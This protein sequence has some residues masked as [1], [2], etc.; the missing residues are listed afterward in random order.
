MKLVF[1]P[2]YFKRI[3]L[4]SFFCS[5]MFFPILTITNLVKINNENTID[6][7]SFQFGEMIGSMVV[8]TH[9]WYGKLCVLLLLI[10]FAFYI[11]AKDKIEDDYLDVLRW[12]SVRLSILICIG[13]NFFGVLINHDLPAKT[14][15][16]VLFISYLITFFIKKNA[17]VQ[18]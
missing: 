8:D 17:S 13:L 14:Q 1:L 6:L 15:L 10:G 5:L 3:G 9:F 7:N 18:S 4:W 12:E 11:L 16:I 2:N